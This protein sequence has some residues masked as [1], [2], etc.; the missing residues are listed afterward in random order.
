MSAALRATELGAVASDW[1][2]L[3]KPRVMTLV[4]FTG[5]IGLAIAPHHINPLSRPGRDPLH[6]RRRGCRGCHQHV[7]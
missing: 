4:V 7:V 3:L 2:A 6:R 1:L 5:A